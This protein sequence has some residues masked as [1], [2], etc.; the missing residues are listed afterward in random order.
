MM[1]LRI[2]NWTKA[3][4]VLWLIF[5]V[6]S[7]VAMAQDKPMES[8]SLTGLITDLKEVV[9]QNSPNKND[10]LIIG[11][12]WD[13]RKDLNGKTKSDVIDL[14]WVD[15][16]S[17]IKDSGVQYQIYSIFSFY[18]QIP[19]NNFSQKTTVAA[20]KPEAVKQLVELTFRMHHYVGIEE[21]IAGLPGTED[22]KTEEARVRQV[23]IESIEEALKVNNKLTPDQKMFVR[24]NYDQI[25]KIADKIVDDTI[26]KNFQSEQWIKEGLQKS[27]TAK[28]TLKE[29]NN[30]VAYFQVETGK[31]V[32]KYIRLTKMEQ[33]ITGNG[34]KIDLTEAD[35][36]EHDK[37]AATALGKNF[38]T[39]Y[40]TDTIAYQQNKENAVRY[41][42]PNADGFAIYEP[43]N[44]NNL[45]NKFVADNYKK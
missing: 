5:S 18:K 40:L 16:K 22:I 6:F 10:A 43:A 45:L 14:L 29:L 38:M 9:S 11:K 3:G 44:L 31:Q 13:A 28:F 12:K 15:V 33:L 19:N 36:A 23:H 32:L 25:I 35:K 39:A 37:F 8:N 2:N 21:Q 26:S 7:L 20:T 34:G 24:A 41:S 17:V 42:N 27:Y 4:L 30:L 1:I